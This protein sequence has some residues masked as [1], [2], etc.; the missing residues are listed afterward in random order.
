MEETT[1]NIVKSKVNFEDL[2]MRD[3]E[4]ALKSMQ[5]GKTQRK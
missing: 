3:V 5:S 1:R 2:S 4:D